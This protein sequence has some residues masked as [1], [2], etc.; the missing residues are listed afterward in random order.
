MKPDIICFPIIDWDFRYQRPQQLLS[1]LARKGHRVFYIQTTFATASSFSLTREEIKRDLA[2][3]AL[4]ENVWN[5][6]LT[7]ARP[8]NLYR[9][10]ITRGGVLSLLLRSLE[11][12]REQEGI[13]NTLLYVNLPFWRPLVEAYR[14]RFAGTI[15]YDCMDNHRGFSTNT[16]QMCAEEDALAEVADQV[17]VSATFLSQQFARLGEKVVLVRNGADFAH[18]HAAQPTSVLAH[19]SPP[20]VGYYGAISEWFDTGLIAAAAH[21]HPEWNFVLIGDTFG[22]DVRPLHS[23]PNVHLL[24]EKPYSDL[25]KYLSRFDVCCIPFYITELTRATDPVK[26]YEY[27]S[28]GKP[29]VA[30]PLPELAPFAEVLYFAADKEEFVSKLEGALRE[31]DPAL[32]QKRVQIAR[33]NDWHSRVEAIERKLS[34]LQLK[35]S[36]IVLTYNNLDYTR[37]CLE[38]LYRCSAY[39][40]WE[41]IVVDNASS[42][43]TVDYLKDFASSQQNV[44]LILNEHNVGF[45]RGNN[46][47]IAAASGEII[48]LLN[49]DVIVTQGWMKKMVAYL[50][51]PEV[52]LVGPVTNGAWNEARVDLGYM[53]LAQMPKAAEAYMREHHGQ[54]FECKV[55][56]AFCLGVRRTLIDEIGSLDERFEVGMFEDDDYSRRVRE[57]GYRIV[58][59]RDI[60]IHHFGGASFF[61]LSWGEYMEIFNA[62]KA[63]YEQKWGEAWEPHQHVEA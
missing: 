36:V 55:L 16:P 51:R 39:E 47:G 49:N 15:V 43:G 50:A 8:L 19:L 53:D 41:L 10:V 44:R 38:S 40:N 1:R 29:V 42:D 9:D 45:A 2:P 37:L 63:R 5:V 32:V 23:L 4:T 27:V 57:K 22:A 60:F 20:I 48:I 34:T 54:S 61:K 56:A 58:C 33:D 31:H 46:L 26:F 30:T 11:A 18:F 62:N 3:R 35:V 7:A 25:P 13:T 28:A 52:G 21:R 12:L 6:T 24:G 14:K 59:A 17:I